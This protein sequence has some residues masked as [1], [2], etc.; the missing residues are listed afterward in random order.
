MQ[1]TGSVNW[2]ILDY[3]DGLKTLVE[4][5]ATKIGDHLIDQEIKEQEKK[6][7]KIEAATAKTKVKSQVL[8]NKPIEVATERRKSPE[9]VSSR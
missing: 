7:K 4:E 2:Q 3:L 5:K 6:Q 9:V 1:E 8:P